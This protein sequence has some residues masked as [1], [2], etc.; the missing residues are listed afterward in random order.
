MPERSALTTL[1]D[2]GDDRPGRL[3]EDG[4]VTARGYSLFKHGDTRYA[5]AFG[6][7]LA[8]HLGSRGGLGERPVWVTASGFGAVPPAAHTLVD[9]FIRQLRDDSP[10]LGPAPPAII[11]FRV[12]RRGV[13]AGDYARMPPGRRRAAMRPGCMSVPG[14]VDLRGARVLALDDIRVTGNHER[15]MHACLL[16]AGADRVE[17]LYLVD[18]HRFAGRPQVESRLNH[19]AVPDLDALLEV[20]RAPW[21]RPNTRVC[22]RVLQLPADRLEHFVGSAPQEV[23]AWIGWAARADRLDRVAVYRPG[24]AAFADLTASRLARAEP[25]TA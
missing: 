17:H 10:G 12:H 9:P 23:L 19:A 25:A 15:A 14:G 5:E 6:S 8:R 16:A 22:R 2:R 4:P 13:S 11:P 7:A 18:A 1:A 20:V 21:F 3:P 24:V